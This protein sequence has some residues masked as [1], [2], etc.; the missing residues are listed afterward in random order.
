MEV[1]DRVI[2][3]LIYYNACVR[4]TLE[5]CLPKESF[6]VNVYEHKKN[7]LTNDLKIQSP[8]KV[9][10]DKQEEKGKET[11]AKL[12]EFIEDFY[13]ENSTVI[14][15]APDGLRVDHAQNVK[16]LKDVVPLHE[17]LNSIVRMHVDFANKNNIKDD[18]VDKLVV[19]DERFYRAVAMLTLSRELFNLFEEYNKARREANGE[20]TPQSNFIESDLNE[21]VKLFMIVKQNATCNDRLYTD[22][23][24]ALLFAIEMMNGRR[25]VPEGK[26]FGDVFQDA[27]QKIGQFVADSEAKW[28]ELYT[29]AINAL[30]E[31]TKAQTTAGGEDVKK[32]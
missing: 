16:I 28:K 13:S 29:P 6:D 4:D 12:E 20:K 24:D 9:F 5:Y 14:K 23:S 27:N 31:D 8:L 17:N 2:V 15:N 21:M 19:Q 11:I 26:N 7:V 10:L 25:Q 18:V 32:A 30:I 3:S 1:I 22:A